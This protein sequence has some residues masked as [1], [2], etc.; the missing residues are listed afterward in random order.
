MKL[1]K[2]IAVLLGVTVMGM[3]ALPPA[4]ALTHGPL[5]ETWNPPGGYTAKATFVTKST[6]TENSVTV[7]L[8]TNRA[9]TLRVDP[10][11][12]YYYGSGSTLYTNSLSMDE[13]PG[14]TKISKP[15]VLGASFSIVQVSAYCEVNGSPRSCLWHDFSLKY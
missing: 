11:V 9:A 8:E 4:S 6:A 7:T 15:Y 5:T 12:K 2:C 13:V 1:K 10:M 3:A 14:I